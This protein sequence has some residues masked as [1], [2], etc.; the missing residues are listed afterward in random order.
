MLL[1]VG[2]RTPALNKGLIWRKQIVN[3]KHNLVAN[4]DV[5]NLL[6]VHSAPVLRVAYCVPNVKIQHQLVLVSS[7]GHKE[8]VVVGVGRSVVALMILYPLISG[9]SD[10]DFFTRLVM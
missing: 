5:V 2:A 4:W 10:W 8:S 3:N 9:E 6:T 1:G 7:W